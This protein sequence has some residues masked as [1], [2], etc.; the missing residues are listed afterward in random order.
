VTALVTKTSPWLNA[1]RFTSAIKQLSRRFNERLAC[2][3]FL[4]A[5]LFAHQRQERRVD[6]A[7]ACHSF[8]SPRARHARARF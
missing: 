1:G 7:L 5:R 8:A 2:H 6:A 3:I 4:I